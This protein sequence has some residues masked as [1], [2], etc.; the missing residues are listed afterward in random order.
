M[1]GREPETWL[2][3]HVKATLEL[4]LGCNT[5]YLFGAGNTNTTAIYAAYQFSQSG[6]R[7]LVNVSPEMQ[8]NS[9][10]SMKEKDIC[11]ILSNS[12]STNMI[13]DIAEIA[14]ARKTKIISVTSYL[15]SPLAKLSDIVLQSVNNDKIS[16][17][18]F[19]S[20]RMCHVAIIDILN[21][22]LIG[23]QDS[24]SFKYNTNLEEYLSKY[25]T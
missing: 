5:M 11:F 12:G 23:N 15:K 10:F 3:R 6:I 17:Q 18:A 1:S 22:L 16:F 20:S 24:E 13:L 4:I 2:S 25:K 21:L 14:K 8:I 7:T 9:A 19:S